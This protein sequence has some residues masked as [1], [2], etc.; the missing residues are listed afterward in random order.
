MTAEDS[1]LEA[2]HRRSGRGA[3][4]AHTTFLILE[5]IPYRVLARGYRT[6]LPSQHSLGEK[7]DAR[8]PLHLRVSRNSLLT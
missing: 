4:L 2:E 7:L 5:E 3:Q 1:E 8:E 6:G